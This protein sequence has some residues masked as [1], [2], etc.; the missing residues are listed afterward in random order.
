MI[1]AQTE[2]CGPPTFHGMVGPLEYALALPFGLF[3][4]FPAWLNFPAKL[5]DG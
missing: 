3:A 1:L 4:L 2:R 5:E